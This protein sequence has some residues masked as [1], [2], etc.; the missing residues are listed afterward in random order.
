[1]PA[2]PAGYLQISIQSVQYVIPY[3]APVSE[4]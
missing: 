2:N 3:Y 4:E 1:L